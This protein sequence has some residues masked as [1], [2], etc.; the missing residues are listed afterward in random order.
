[1]KSIANGSGNSADAD[2]DY[3]QFS[4]FDTEEENSDIEK[5]I[6]EL[7]LSNMT[8]IEAL[9]ILFELQK[10]IGSGADK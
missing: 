4:L 5:E 2:I 10:K 9:N 1:M 7:N 8:P 6:S 3:R